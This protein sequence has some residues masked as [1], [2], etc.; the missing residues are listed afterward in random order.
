YAGL[1]PKKVTAR[2]TRRCYGV[3]VNDIFE[4]GV[5]PL[6]FKIIRPD[7]PRCTNRFS[8]FVRKGQKVQMDE[9]V[10]NSYSAMK[11]HAM[12]DFSVRIFAIDGYPPRYTTD[13][14]VSKLAKISVPNPFKSSDPIGHK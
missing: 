4:E 8:T 1:N 11:V 14:G 5:D 12:H 3:G 13:T 6:D 7:G 2:V 10:T 9:C